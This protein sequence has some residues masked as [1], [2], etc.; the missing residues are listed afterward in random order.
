MWERLSEVVLCNCLFPIRNL[1]NKY[2]MFEGLIAV[3]LIFFWNNDAV[4]GGNPM[5]LISKGFI[6]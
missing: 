2:R 3:T 6:S 4:K 5:L 1:P